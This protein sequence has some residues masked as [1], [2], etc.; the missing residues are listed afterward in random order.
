M[1][2]LARLGSLW[3]EGFLLFVVF[4][5]FICQLVSAVSCC[6]G[7]PICQP[8]SLSPLP[9]F[10]CE[11]DVGLHFLFLS[12]QLH[13]A[14]LQDAG[15]AGHAHFHLAVGRKCVLAEIRRPARA[16]CGSARLPV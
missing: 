8:L 7:N 12:L 11:D 16:V 13:P 14:A 4:F 2:A 3:F 15:Q 6:R 5:F 1:A 10:P 9:L